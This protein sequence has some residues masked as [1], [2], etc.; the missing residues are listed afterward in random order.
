MGVPETW[1]E[2]NDLLRDAD[3]AT[4][5]LLLRD[6]LRGKR[7]PRFLGRIYSRFNRVRAHSERAALLDGGRM[8]R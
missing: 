4:C 2:L 7:R 6:E 1:M 5:R 8:P 3:E